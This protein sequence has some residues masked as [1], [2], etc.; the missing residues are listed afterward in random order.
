MRVHILIIL[1]AA[2]AAAQSHGE[3]Q[4]PDGKTAEQVYKNITE[5]KGTPADLVMPAMQFISAVLGVECSFCHV[6][7][8]F[9]AD[10]KLAKRT[11]RSPLSMTRAINLYSFRGHQQVTCYSCHH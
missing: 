3:V 7:D 6:Q 2:S 9:E 8:K 1:G 5:L 10:D 4:P 11:A